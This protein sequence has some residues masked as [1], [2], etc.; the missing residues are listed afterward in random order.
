MKLLFYCTF[1][2]LLCT[3]AAQTSSVDKHGK[4]LEKHGKPDEAIEQY[5]RALASNPDDLKAH[6]AI[7]RILRAK[8]NHEALADEYRSWVDSHP[9]DFSEVSQLAAE[10]GSFLYDQ[11]SA[12]D[13]WQ[14]YLSQ[15]PPPATG[16]TAH[17]ALGQLL[18]ERERYSEA[19]SELRRATQLQTDA[20]DFHR[21]LADALVAKGD[22]NGALQEYRAESYLAPDR[23][24]AHYAIAEVLRK[25]GDLEGELTEYGAALNVSSSKSFA[26]VKLAILLQE[27]GDTVAAKAQYKQAI[28]EYPENTYAQVKLAKLVPTP[29]ADSD[30]TRAAPLQKRDSPASP[31]NAVNKVAKNEQSVDPSW[32]D[33]DAAAHYRLGIAALAYQDYKLVEVELREAVRLDPTKTDYHKVLG[34]VLVETGD[35]AGAIREL[36]AGIRSSNPVESA[37]D[38]HALALLLLKWKKNQ[39]AIEE[40]SRAYTLVPTNFT[41]RTDYERMQSIKEEARR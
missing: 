27:R 16:A 25:M 9:A 26:R 32:T 18:L 7:C 1:V 6:L 5:R 12:I 8:E 38:H 17:N 21:D 33:A 29:A 24:D 23:A 35:Q 3:C 28:I 14:D 31:N 19:A 15:S 39:D 40:F 30:A 20:P 37:V 11:E 2:F 4:A 13:V 34:L 41:F 36:K 10:L 22:L